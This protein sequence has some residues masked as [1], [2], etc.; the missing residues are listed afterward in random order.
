MARVDAR[1]LSTVV[2]LLAAA[3]C[4][5][6]TAPQ[7]GPPAR[8]E[9]TSGATFSG[10]VATALATPLA[11]RV[12]DAQGRG[13]RGAIVR[14]SLLR[15]GGSLEPLSATTGSRGEA[16]TTLAFGPTAGGYE[17]VANVSRVELP[18]RF[19]GTA[20]PGDAARVV[21]TP[22][23]VRMSAVGDSSRFRARQYD[24]HGNVV[25]GGTIVWTAADAD[26]FTIEQNGVVRGTRAP[27][28]GRVIA[29]VNDR[30]DTGF[31]VIADPTASRCLGYSPPASLAVG[32]GLDVSMTDG[33]CIASAG[34]D[35]YVLVPWH[36]STTGAATATLQIVGSGLSPVTDPQAVAPSVASRASVASGDPE[37]GLALEAR[38]R[39]MG[40][41]EV[42]PLARRVRE[43]VGDRLAPSYDR[44]GAIPT[45]VALGEFLELNANAN[46][47][48]AVPSM[49]T[50]RVAAVSARA[51]V[52]HDTANP[53]G[54]FTDSDY[55]RF[56]VTFDT[57]IT[58][59]NDAAFGAPTDIDRNAKVVIFFTRAVNELTP[60]GA[61]FYYG[62]FF[63]PRDL[64]PR[65]QNG[66]AFCEGSNE[67]EMFYMLVPDPAGEVN[68]NR[69]RIG[70]V[71]SVTIGTLAHEYQHLVNAG[72]RAY[73]NDAT[74]DEEVWL[75]EGLSHI[76]EE[77]VFYRATGMAPRQNLGGAQF[78]A[79]PYDGLFTEYLAPNVARLRVFLLNT[80]NFS[81]YT[82]GDG[83]ATRG[84]VWTF[85]RY[86]ADRRG[87]GDGDVWMRLVNTRT[88]G[89][90]NLAEVFGPD[91]LRMLREWTV[92]L[93]TDDYVPGVASPLSQPSWNFRSAFPALP[94]L[95]RSYPLLEGVR[96]LA[97]D[98]T[99]TVVLNGGSGA[100]LRF[101]VAAGRAAAIRVTSNGFAPPATVRATIVRTR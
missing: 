29:R 10:T 91:V 86:L 83:L 30:A 75:N 62:G 6:G 52:V 50:G 96:T 39:E 42:M 73:V 44:R 37:R 67:G 98:A 47:S 3:A 82:A 5:D 70:F 71:D 33:A 77:L 79:Q 20:S 94:V 32:Q 12:V 55:Q 59:V 40:R 13:V 95:P 53:A 80:H 54:G 90:V 60:A 9:V 81:P 15:G 35:E 72:R 65:Q 19:V 21:V 89:L 24:A 43:T 8:I 85:L 46:A 76:A 34:D 88:A 93:Y 17:I 26:V 99:Q 97:D 92:S 61:T 74:T 41:R 58:P 11:V 4:S 28:I 36:G 63:H 16:A 101:S 49:R 57:L 51:V 45:N 31:V 69:R 84:A 27:A 48:C 7:A 14:F 78:G 38:I 64:L 2:A 56:A 87:A 22:G 18:G 25:P 68:G 100:F 23:Q 1:A 66:A